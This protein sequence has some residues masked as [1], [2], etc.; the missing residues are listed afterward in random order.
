MGFKV[1]QH[2][3][4]LGAKISIHDRAKY[5]SY[6][7]Q[8]GTANPF[9][10]INIGIY[11]AP[12]FADLDADGDLD[13]L[14][15]EYDGILNYYKNTGSSSNPVYSLQTGT[16]NPFNGINVGNYSTPTLADL[17]ADGDLDALIGEYDGILNYYKN[18]GSSS[19]PVYTPQTGTANPFNGINVGSYS[20]PTLADLDGDGDLDA[21]IGKKD[22]TLNYYQNTGSSSNP[23]Y[24]PQTG[25]ANPFNGINVGNYSTPTLADLDGDGDLDALIGEGDGTLNYFESVVPNTAPTITSGASVNFAENGTGTAYQVIATDPESN[26]IT[27]GLNQT[28]D[29]NLFNINSATGL[30]TFKTAPN[31]ESPTDAGANNVYDI[32]VT[33]SDASLTTSK[34]VAITVTDVNPENFVTT[35]NQDQ[36]SLGTGDDS[37][38]ST[39]ANLQ[40]NDNI[41]A[42]GGTDTF[43]LT[44]G[45]ASD[46]LG[47]DAS[48]SNNQI[49]I[50]GT[51]LTNF[52]RFDLSGFLG[53]VSF[54]GLSGNNWIK[55]GAGKDDLTGYNGNDYLNGGTGVD[56][57]VGG[58]GNDTYV[59]DN[60][61]DLITEGLNAGIDSVESSL[62]WTLTV[63]LE[64]L[65]LTGTAAINGTGNT[66]A[67]LLTGN[68]ANNSLNGDAGN[69][70]L[71]ANDGNDTLNG[72]DGND[73]LNG[74]TG[75]DSLTGGTGADTL[76]GGTGNDVYYIDN[77]LDTITELSGEG[78]DTVYIPRTVV[79]GVF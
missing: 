51:S 18:T 21:L 75:N 24:T 20:T 30:V 59:V 71:T 58:N 13:A 60:T 1:P 46:S 70:T 19:N 49:D 79:I 52:E 7:E 65:T 61:G 76:T 27:Y 6:I 31:Y 8:T 14:I 78:T 42:L 47:I 25:T 32:T 2:W 77:A 37:L 16:A 28:G 72:G 68:S 11:S 23:V 44:G 12:T 15:G 36:F 40:Q 5:N 66:L 73:T 10:G 26:P 48:D 74:G 41:N 54:K 39:L 38:T 53:T 50:A 55:S 9:N 56:Q 29:W 17:D 64:N 63:N 33:A 34:A 67:N 62:T 69:D 35:S 57:L 22:G 4:I 45:T 43:I 3:G